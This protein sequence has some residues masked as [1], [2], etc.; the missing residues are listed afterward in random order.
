MARVL[1]VAQCQDAKKW[2]QGFVTHADLFRSMGATA[3]VNYGHE[4]N[5]VAVMLDVKDLDNY[6]RVLNSK[7]TADA[8]AIDGVL[9]ETVKMFVLNKQLV[10]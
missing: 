5:W 7:A 4:G 10:V 3:P 1:V 2:E 8:M 6:K 9:R